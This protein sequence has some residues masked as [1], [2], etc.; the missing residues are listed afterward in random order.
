MGKAYMAPKMRALSELDFSKYEIFSFDKL[1]STCL[2]R[3]L[4]S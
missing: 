2:K 4:E 1:N 3:H